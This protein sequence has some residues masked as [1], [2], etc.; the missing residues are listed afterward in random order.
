MLLE[1]LKKAVN[2]YSALVFTFT[3]LV[4]ILFGC[5]IFNINLAAQLIVVLCLIAVFFVM[6]TKRKALNS[7]V[8]EFGA[9]YKVADRKITR[10][11]VQ[12]LL[13]VF[14]K[15]NVTEKETEIAVK[16]ILRG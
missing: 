9:Y 5:M 16:K 11:D 1:N 6:R 12:A 7:A 13:Q 3:I 4:F 14:A 15:K 10:R 8:K 2:E